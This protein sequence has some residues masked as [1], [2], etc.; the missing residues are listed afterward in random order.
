LNSLSLEEYQLLIAESET[1]E[2]D[3]H[4]V[5]VLLTSKGRIV[6]LFRLKRLISSARLKSY[7]SRFVDNAFAL[8][9]LGI[10]TVD[11]EGVFYCKPI[12]RTLVFYLPI[13]GR[14]LRTVLQDQTC[15]DDVMKRFATFLAKLH[16][17]GVF[18]RSIHLNN[19]IVSDDLNS[20]GLIDMADMKVVQGQLSLQMRKRN[21]RHLT[22]YKEDQKAIVRFGLSKFMAIYFSE[23]DLP[24]AQKNELTVL[25]KTLTGAEGLL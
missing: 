2:K 19:V 8:K 14:T 18:F 3:R 7:S 17:K 22:R 1:L 9:R 10:K 16:D 20:L 6:K 5:K 23:S 13:P 24:A 21:F 11:V 25:M 12:K 4:G 15:C